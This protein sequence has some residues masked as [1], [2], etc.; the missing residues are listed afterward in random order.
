MKKEKKLTNHIADVVA[1]M[2]ETSREEIYID[3]IHEYDYSKDDAD[4][5]LTIYTLYYSDWPEWVDSLK[6]TI[7]LQIVDT[8]NGV[9]IE[10][11]SSSEEI[12]YLKLEQLHILLRLTS[13][14]KSFKKSEPSYKLDF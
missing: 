10:N 9:V 8:G 7:A 4:N 3:G 5:D 1:K 13:E 12:D 6:N 11:L 2:L 14:S